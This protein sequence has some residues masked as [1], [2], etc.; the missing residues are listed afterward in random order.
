MTVPSIDTWI[1]IFS[2]HD[3]PFIGV[4]ARNSPGERDSYTHP[5]WARDSVTALTKPG[6][7]RLKLRLLAEYAGKPKVIY[8]S[9]IER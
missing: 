6:G 3:E 4:W 8:S 1:T 9:P 5:R 7:R 2:P